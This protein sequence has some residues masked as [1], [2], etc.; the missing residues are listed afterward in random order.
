MHE[1]RGAG[2]PGCHGPPT[3]DPQGHC[4]G[5][6]RGGEVGENSPQ[7]NRPG[8]ARG[9]GRGPMGRR[10]NVRS[11]GFLADKEGDRRWGP[12]RPRP[13]SSCPRPPPHGHRSTRRGRPRAAG[14]EP[15]GRA[16][17]TPGAPHQPPH[18]WLPGATPLPSPEAQ[19]RVPGGPGCP[20]PPPIP[21]RPPRPPGPQPPPPARRDSAQL[22]LS[23]SA[24]W[25]LP[26]FFLF[27]FQSMTLLLRCGRVT[28]R[29]GPGSR[30]SR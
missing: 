1:G 9:V 23:L 29:G 17:P 2:L 24:C 13:P 5:G 14:A 11:S 16:P 7:P 22:L 20:S 4:G 6:R 15:V 21:G 18:Q 10:Q 3:R 26:F 27:L 12:R 30:Q 19:G 8:R 25:W 28:V